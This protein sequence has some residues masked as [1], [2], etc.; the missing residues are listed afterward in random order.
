MVDFA[1]NRVARSIGVSRYT[2][3]A[4]NVG[5]VKLQVC[6]SISIALPLLFFITSET[7]QRHLYVHVYIRNRCIVMFIFYCTGA[8]SL[9][10]NG[11]NELLLQDPK[12]KN[13]YR[14]FKR[15]LNTAQ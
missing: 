8:T 10:Y 15:R 7:S 12:T 3:L 13:P 14:S 2:C 11:G 9:F 5:L 6:D 4:Y 1:L